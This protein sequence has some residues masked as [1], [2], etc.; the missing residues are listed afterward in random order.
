MIDNI[1]PENRGIKRRLSLRDAPKMLRHGDWSQC[2]GILQWSHL[3]II[4]VIQQLLEVAETE[5][6]VQIINS[7]IDECKQKIAKVA[8]RWNEEV[9]KC[10]DFAGEYDSGGKSD[11][12]G[13]SS[14]DKR[15]GIHTYM[16]DQ[17]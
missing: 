8:C 13:M 14:A 1:D 2:S 11:A 15:G 6:S 9:Q 17:I 7:A 10:D 12:Y 5:S 4:N 3:H 16:A